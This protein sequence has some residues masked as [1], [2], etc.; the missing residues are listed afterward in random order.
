M[1]S[2][3]QEILSST[4]AETMEKMAFI[5]SDPLDK[6]E[7]AVEE[8]KYLSAVISFSG[9]YRG[10]IE[11][12]APQQTC[13]I[14]AANMLGLEPEEQESEQKAVD[15]FKETLNIL[16]GQY[17]TNAFGRDEVFLLSTPQGEIC[18]FEKVNNMVQ[19]EDVIC[20]SVEEQPFVVTAVVAEQGQRVGAA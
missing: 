11:I 16:C 17:L 5:F 9:K 15:A 8:Q 4:F 2:K 7:V 13:N 18:S 10:I 14:I 1:D 12:A 19:S 6:S 20:F 3:T